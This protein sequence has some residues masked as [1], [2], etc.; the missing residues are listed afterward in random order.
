M[1]NFHHPFKPYDIQTQLMTA[2]YDTIA[3]GYKVGLFE[4]PTGTGKTLSIICSVMSWLREY[5]TKNP[6][7]G[8]QQN[9]TEVSDDE[10]S[11]VTEA[12]ESTVL[13]KIKEKQREYEIVLE[14]V[15]SQKRG[16]VVHKVKEREFKRVK[17]NTDQE[18]LDDSQFLLKDYNANEKNDLDSIQDEVNALLK[19]ISQKDSNSDPFQ[20]L[21]R[22]QT[23]I[24]FSSRT[25][26]QLNQFT[27]QL[28]LT[29]FPSS[30]GAVEEHIKYLPIGSRKQLCI[31]PKV[32]HYQSLPLLNEACLEAQKDSNCKYY[33]QPNN[34]QT[35]QR[36]QEFRDYTYSEIHDIED[37]NGIGESLDICPYYSIRKSIPLSEIISLPYQM[38]LERNTRQILNIDLRNSIVIVDEAHN[39]MDTIMALNST[40]LSYKELI[41]MR[42]SLKYYLQK[43][44]TRM[45]SGNRIN[46]LKLVKLTELLLTYIKRKK[47][48][49]IKPGEKLDLMDIFPTNVD[50]NIFQLETYLTTSKLAFKVETYMEKCSGRHANH[51]SPL[52]FKLKKFLSS[53][54]H[55][56]DNGCFFFEVAGD[57]I[58][59]K[60]LLL[61]PSEIFQDIVDESRC[62]ILAGGTMEP[63]E[64]YVNFLFKHTPRNKIK[65]FSCDHIIPKNNLKVFALSNG[66]E[67]NL[68]NFSFSNRESPAIIK[69]LGTSILK[70]V[71]CVPGG[72]VIFFPS[73]K[74]LEKVVEHWKLTSPLMWST[75]NRL[76]DIFTEPTDSGKVE[77]VLSDYSRKISENPKRG[78]ILFSVVG[79]KMSEGINFQDD[80]ARGIIMVGLPFPNAFSGELIARRKFIEDSVL[81]ETNSRKAS[82]QASK[83]FYENICMRSV[84]Q[85]VGRAIRH[86]NDYAVIF[87][88]DNRYNNTNIQQKLSGWIRKRFASF[89]MSKAISETEDFFRNRKLHQ[90]K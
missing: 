42:K 13:P 71:Q 25:H 89:T 70:I 90:V 40:S 15:K 26:S 68:L 67:G 14:K 74:Y 79:G 7:Q 19:K 9:E 51:A 5:K 78:A 37:L 18:E 58:S 39:L 80:L 41:D 62:V 77:D 36:M 33:D 6:D 47:E 4:S 72:T 46:C 3:G 35:M 1:E 23:R 61:D 60:F 65:M 63:M 52:L 34:P 28:R 45:N 69:D 8:S 20:N 12:Y 21:E 11:W 48:T 2:I 75:L 87:L 31:N 83:D 24:L 86:I 56:S 50:I 64:D 29:S 81:K 54:S 43:F 10:P 66:M 30:L 53:L 44:S 22:S 88:L 73:Y 38:L 16:K 76:K 55:P 49:R 85:S 82:L 57:D 84:N 59:L 32:N 27:S 17:K